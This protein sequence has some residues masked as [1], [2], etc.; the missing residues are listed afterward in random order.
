MF[1]NLLSSITESVCNAV[2]AGFQKA[3]DKL[4]AEG[5]QNKPAPLQL[6]LAHREPEEDDDSDDVERTPATSNGKARKR[7]M[8]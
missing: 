6:T 7:V 1:A 8:A 3:F 5:L 4:D 2:L